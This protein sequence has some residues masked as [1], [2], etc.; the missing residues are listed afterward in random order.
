MRTRLLQ[1]SNLDGKRAAQSFHY[2]T[3][4]ALYRLEYIRVSEK[5]YS[6]CAYFY[7]LNEAKEVGNRLINEG[8]ARKAR[9]IIIPVNSRDTM[10]V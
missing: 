2:M 3:P 10:N 5:T 7:D 6:D 8:V 4:T 1:V 9:I